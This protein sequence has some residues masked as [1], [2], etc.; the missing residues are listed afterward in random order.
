MGHL[1]LALHELLTN[2]VAHGALSNADGDVA[3]RWNVDMG[4]AKRKLILT[5]RERGGPKVSPPTSRGM[6][7][8]L[9]E[10]GLPHALDGQGKADFASEGFRLEITA[11]LSGTVQLA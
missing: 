6:G 11:P 3:L 4:A 8:R 5:W 10:Q 1:H 7:M 2:A 9:I